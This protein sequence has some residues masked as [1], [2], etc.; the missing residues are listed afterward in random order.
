MTLINGNRK[1]KRHTGSTKG[2]LEAQKAL[3]EAGSVAGLF[4]FLPV[5]YHGLGFDAK[6]IA[7]LLTGSSCCSFV[8]GLVWGRIADVTG[9]YKQ[10][11]VVT[12]TLAS[13]LVFAFTL[14]W[15]KASEYYILATVSR[16]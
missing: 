1:R 13:G 6:T 8:G 15:V 10:I 14:G 11:I 7:W 2:L 16:V 3:R 4:K 12:A 5:F 9:A